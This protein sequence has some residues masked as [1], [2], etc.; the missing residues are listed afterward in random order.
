[1]THCPPSASAIRPVPRIPIRLEH[2]GLVERRRNPEAP[3]RVEYSLTEAGHDLL[4]PI[5][6]LG[7]WAF[8]HANAVLT[9]QDSTA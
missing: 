1:L 2:N 4:I 8:K 7:D 5:Q 3:P 9:A 6:A